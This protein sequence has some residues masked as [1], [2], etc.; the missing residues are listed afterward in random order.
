MSESSEDIDLGELEDGLRASAPSMDLPARVGLDE[1]RRRLFPDVDVEPV[2][3]NVGRFVVHRKIGAGAMGVVFEAWDPKLGRKI[4][5]KVLRDL[6]GQGDETARVLGE[7]RALAKLRHP[8]IVAVHDVGVHDGRPFIAMDYVD[9]ETLT[10]W[11]ERRHPQR[12]IVDLFLSIARGLAAAHEVGVVHRDFKPDNVLVTAANEPFV[13][14]FGVARTVTESTPKDEEAAEA[15][16]RSTTSVAGTPAYMAPEQARGAPADARADQFS[17]ASTLYEA[18]M[19]TRPFSGSTDAR[20]IEA[21]EAGRLAPTRPGHACPRPLL[22]IMARALSFDPAARFPSM[23]HLVE[24][25]ERTRRRARRRR[26]TGLGLGAA[27]VGAMLS[28]ALFSAPAESVVDCQQF[29]EPLEGV[30]NG[31]A[32]QRVAAAFAGSEAAYADDAMRRVVAAL[33]AYV[34]DY[35]QLRV[36][37]CRATHVEGTQSTSTLELQVACL[38]RRLA[39]VEGLI[40]TFEQ[41]D[42]KTVRLAAEAVSA[43]TPAS[44]CSDTEALARVDRLS[45]LPEEPRARARV[46]TLRRSLARLRSLHHAGRYEDGLHRARELLDEAVAV[47]HLPSIAAARHRIGAFQ[48]DLG[49]PQAAEI[50]LDKAFLHAVSGGDDEAAAEI[51]TTLG[52]VVGIVLRRSDEGQRWARIAGAMAERLGHPAALTG[53]TALQRGNTAL[54]QGQYDNGRTALNEAAAAFESAGLEGERGE[55]LSNLAVLERR[56]GRLDD[57]VRRFDEAEEILLRVYGPHHPRMSTLWNNRAALDMQME[58]WEDAEARLER[59]LTV[60][61]ETAGP[62]HP[63][64]GHVCNNL[65]EVHAARDEH[66]Q[67]LDLFDRAHGI[68]TTALGPEH[69]LVAYV[70]T[71]RSLSLS[72]EGRREEAERDAMRSLELRRKGGAT[73]TELGRTHYALGLA[74]SDERPGV[75]REHMLRAREAFADAE[76]SA[77]AADIDRWFASVPKKP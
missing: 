56:A 16:P 31:E 1:L 57:A 20:R 77:L 45:P 62:E 7:A 51:A 58:R 50:Q 54:L 6:Y 3:P 44:V 34:A 10:A 35:E 33:D 39:E 76:D 69:P 17:F 25:I 68:W 9:G 74:L 40:E 19:G 49:E 60:V 72:A 65:G 13:V 73:G 43:L 15:A 5:L 59:A 67:A 52:H 29:G 30:W 42:A 70:L 4:A 8:S 75:A 23:G 38:D 18:L 46:Q 11:M 66:D 12:R 48:V 21:I 22:R 24:E 37:S 2:V 27:G 53:R 61:T 47:D 14:D 63:M 64:T 55:T 41:A 32:K 26:L 28:F 36:A 71:E